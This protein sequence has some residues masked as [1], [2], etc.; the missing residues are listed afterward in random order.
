MKE[1][2]ANL[3]EVHEQD[4]N[5]SVTK[6]LEELRKRLIHAIVAI[7]IGSC[8]SYFF[9]EDIIDYLTLP[10][11]KLYYLQP[12]EAFFTYIKVAILGGLLLALPF[13]FYEAWSFI[14]PA[15]TLSERTIFSFLVPFSVILFLLGISFSFFFV[16][17][18]GLK[19]FLG[20]G[21]ENLSPLISLGKY[22][23][24]VLAFI[25]PFGIIFELPLIV[26]V[27]AKLGLLKSSFLASK[28]KI[29]IFL[30]FV[31]GAVVSPTPD[32]F[33]QTMIAV[34]MILLY[35]ISLFIVRFILRK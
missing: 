5:M 11:G 30:S 25:L 24:F 10:V 1:K 7:V 14:L 28:R 3:E 23:D 17:P 19:F 32:I 34:P 2:L 16:L 8:C 18:L 29:F 9:I 12:A 15:L 31:V 26:I 27:F 22:F 33:S 4:G 6:H 20:F 13:V 35:E 21:N